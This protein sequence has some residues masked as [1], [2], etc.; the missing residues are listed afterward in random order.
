LGIQNVF[1]EVLPRNKSSFVEKLKNEGRVVSFVGDGINDSPALA[2]ANVGIAIGAGTDIAMETASIILMKSD[3]RDVI[4][5][6]DLSKTTYR[7]I[8]LNFLW[9]F[10]YNL[11]GIP[12]AAGVFFPLIKVSLPPMAAGGAMALSSVSVVISSLL[13][14]EI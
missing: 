12:L 11:L 14:K 5:A 13:F 2:A 10:C 1:A 4:T 3:L 8:R 6:I 9:A 7:R